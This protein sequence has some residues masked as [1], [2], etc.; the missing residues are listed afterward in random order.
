[1]KS[2]APGPG[3]DT[4]DLIVRVSAYL[5]P[6][7]AA[8]EPPGDR[9]GARLR[10]R[11]RL[12]V[13]IGAGRG[14]RRGSATSPERVQLRRSTVSAARAWARARASLTWE[15]VATTRRD[16]PP[17]AGFQEHCS[18]WV[19]LRCAKSW[20]SGRELPEQGVTRSVE[21]DPKVRL[22]ANPSPRRISIQAV[23]VVSIAVRAAASAADWDCR[24]S[25]VAL[26]STST[27]TAADQDDDAQEHGGEHRR[28]TGVR[29]CSHLLPA[30]QPSAVAS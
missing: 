10:L 20:A 26:P 16:T 29:L 30:H 3:D 2:S 11:L 15:P 21:P 25:L 9:L 23:A 18:R 28:G 8:G 27:G 4:D 6:V 24:C 5:Q 14:S 12:R 19:W 17:V 13:R 22:G 1:M 7:G